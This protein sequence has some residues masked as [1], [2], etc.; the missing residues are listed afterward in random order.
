MWK[1]CSCLYL[2]LCDDRIDIQ[3]DAVQHI[4]LLSND[5]LYQWHSCGLRLDEVDDD[6]VKMKV[7]HRTYCTP[8]RYCLQKKLNT[9]AT[10]CIC[11]SLSGQLQLNFV[12]HI[13]TKTQRRPMRIAKPWSSP[14]FSPLD[15]WATLL[16]RWSIKM[17]RDDDNDPVKCKIMKRKTLSMEAARRETM[18]VQNN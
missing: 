9:N 13:C 10:N 15:C 1:P 11:W 17:L 14:W 12:M 8:P 18:W 3:S 5:Q 4:E 16:L 2:A 7:M 6:Q